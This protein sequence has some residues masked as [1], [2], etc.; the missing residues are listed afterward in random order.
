[1]SLASTV[2]GATASIGQLQETGRGVASSIGSIR[3]AVG[4]NAG[5]LGREASVRVNSGN[6]LAR[7]V[8][9]MWALVG[10]STGLVQE[11]N[12]ITSGAG[13]ALATRWAQVQA[14]M[15]DAG[16]NLISSA[17]I[18]QSTSV[19]L[20]KQGQ[21]ETKWLV[22]LDSGGAA[23]GFRQAGFGITGSAS[24]NG[25]NYA[26][27][28]RADTFWIAG[29]GEPATGG[30]PPAKV[31]FIVRASGWIDGRGY[32]QPPGVY[33]NDLF[34]TTAIIGDAQITAA[35]IGAAQIKAA[36][37]DNAQIQTAHI[38]NAQVDTLRI[39]SNAVTLANTAYLDAGPSY[40]VLRISFESY[41]NPIFIIGFAEKAPA[42]NYALSL[43]LW[44][45][46]SPYEGGGTCISRASTKDPNLTVMTVDHP[47]PG[48]RTYFIR[49]SRVGGFRNFCFFVLETKR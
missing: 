19:L 31:P 17:A 35:K 44:R 40:D 47:G 24:A 48:V 25:P 11:G 29:P 39:G 41:G 36:H 13:G 34:A 15:S 16:G 1:T 42:E 27:G 33:L 5:A 28:V 32:W 20:D 10:N 37:I 49:C 22:N 21:V 45:D 2:G 6:A 30:A 14:S 43:D 18:R 12:E 9:A 38:G 3:A 8:N 4:E 23:M 26:F 7:A 46:H